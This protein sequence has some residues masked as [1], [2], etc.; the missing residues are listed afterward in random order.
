MPE[1]IAN[2][3]EWISIN[4]RAIVGTITSSTLASNAFLWLS[5][6]KQKKAVTDNTKATN[7]LNDATEKLNGAKTAIETNT[8][9]TVDLKTEITALTR[10]NVELKNSLDTMA[11]KISSILEVLDIVYGTIKD[12]T[13][14]TA[15]HN[16][17]L[18]SKYTENATRAELQKQIEDLQSKVAED[19]ALLQAQVK[20][21]VDK[22][23]K[24]VSG[25]KL[26]GRY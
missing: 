22:V 11:N 24:T 9:E 14:R 6:G 10:E 25:N 7:D 2:I 26:T 1:F 23:K 17:I 20:D 8:K 3:C 18:N 16:I 4:W 15:V 12:E 13:V 21:T 5:L 19:A